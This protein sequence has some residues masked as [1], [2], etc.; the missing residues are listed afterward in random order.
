[1]STLNSPIEAQ[2]AAAHRPLGDL[3]M[4]A[5]S[6]R[7]VP[8][9]HPGAVATDILDEQRISARKAAKAIGL[10]AAGLLKVLNGKGPITPETALRFA[11]YFGNTPEHWLRMQ[12]DHDLWHARSVMAKQLGKIE[13]IAP[14]QSAK[15]GA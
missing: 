14:S 13:S 6:T 2:G 5:H 15:P 10:S 7:K 1:M 12:N 4:A 8:P 11:A 9:L 3:A